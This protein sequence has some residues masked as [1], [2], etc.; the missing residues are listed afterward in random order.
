MN[1]LELAQ[2]LAD[3]YGLPVKVCDGS[4]GECGDQLVKIEK[5]PRKESR[6]QIVINELWDAFH[7]FDYEKFY[8]IKSSANL[9][10][11]QISAVINRIESHPTWGKSLA[12]HEAWMAKREKEAAKAWEKE[13]EFDA[14]HGLH[15]KHANTWFGQ[16]LFDPEYKKVCQRLGII[17]IIRNPTLIIARDGTIHKKTKGKKARLVCE[18]NKCH[19]VSFEKNPFT[20]NQKIDEPLILRS[21]SKQ[22]TL[23]GIKI[24]L[25]PKSKEPIK[26]EDSHLVELKKTR[27]TPTVKI[28]SPEDVVQY[29]S[30]M[31]DYDREKAKILH[32][33]TKNQIVGVE[34]ISTG[35]LNASIVHPRE[36]LKGAILN[37]SAA[38]I[39][40]HN[41]PSGN[42]EPSR[43]DKEVHARLK[44][45]FGT[46][47]IELLDSIVIGKDG[48][49]SLKEEGL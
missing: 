20:Y 18:G 9:K 37:N 30:H 45:A 7:G 1:A 25:Q 16:T 10:N 49:R 8:R 17:P 47:G 14:L 15:H 41:H 40:V 13:L 5:N 22:A 34:N 38:V 2:K 3:H 26:L 19:V 42:P 23:E 44:N 12:L 27:K 35:S 6:A 31:G 33:N 48:Y 21:D 32:L 11:P 46:V 29:L 43:E 24:E 39:F 36:A 28:G 4:I